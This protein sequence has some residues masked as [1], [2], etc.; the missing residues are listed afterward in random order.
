MNVHSITFIDVTSESFPILFSQIAEK[1]LSNNHNP[2][3]YPESRR[4]DRVVDTS[5]WLID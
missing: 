2:F 5:K 1:R 4:E 3:F